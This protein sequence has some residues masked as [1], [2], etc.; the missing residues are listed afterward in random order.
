MHHAVAGSRFR[1]TG[2]P[3]TALQSACSCS[4]WLRTSLLGVWDMKWAWGGGWRL[5]AF[6]CQTTSSPG[7]CPISRAHFRD[8]NVCTTRGLPCS[9]RA[10]SLSTVDEVCSLS[11]LYQELSVQLLLVEAEVHTQVAPDFNIKLNMDWITALSTGL[12]EAVL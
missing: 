2:A 12:V 1:S 10:A 8:E 6:L 9:L 11:Q 5:P 3:T 4:R 7:F